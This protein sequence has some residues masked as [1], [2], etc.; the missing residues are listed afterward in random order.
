MSQPDL[1]LARA[2]SQ[3]GF[4]RAD[5]GAP[6]AITVAEHEQHSVVDTCARLL[7]Q[8]GYIVHADNNLVSKERT[9]A[10]PEDDNE[11]NAT[12]PQEADV[13]PTVAV[14]RHPVLGVVATTATPGIGQADG[15]LL[16]AGFHFVEHQGLYCLPYGAPLDEALNRVTRL[17]LGLDL[18][19]IPFDISRD[20]NHPVAGQPLTSRVPAV[21]PQPP[22]TVAS[23]PFQ[24]LLGRI[25]RFF[26]RLGDELV[27]IMKPTPP[28]PPWRPGTLPP[29][30]RSA[31]TVWI[32]V[33]AQQPPWKP[34]AFID[35]APSTT[36]QAAIDHYERSLTQA[37]SQSR[38][39]IAPLKPTN[40]VASGTGNRPTPVS[41]PTA[42]T[43]PPEAAGPR[44][45]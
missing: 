43:T 19:H 5:P 6:H 22:Q 30:P 38:S 36:I 28:Q 16:N 11:L 13:D 33:P 24:R 18:A 31:G 41:A 25:D 42:Q 21:F 44:R 34:P 12:N 39:T 4:T 8:A 17:T 15:V 3:L 9:E 27:N 1:I 20:I 45:R 35:P 23:S 14:Y 2:L 32:Q 29:G 7:H 10:A 26:Q 40:P 37:A